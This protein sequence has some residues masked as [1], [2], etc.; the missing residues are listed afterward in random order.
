MNSNKSKASLILAM[1]I[2]GTIGVFR[3]YIPF[4]SGFIAFSRGLLGTSFLLLTAFIRGRRLSFQAIRNNIILLIVSG[5]LIG[6]NWILLFESYRYTTVAT[7]TLCYYMAPI[8][9][10]LASPLV[11]SEKLSARKI[12]CV[13]IALFG[14]VLVSGIFK[15]EF[16]GV[17]ELYG[18]FFGLGAAV[19]Y[20]SVIILNKKL[21]EIPANEKTIMQLLSAAIVVLP[22]TLFAENISEIIFTPFA[23]TLLLIVG[24]IHTGLSY[25][26]YFNSFK[27]LKAQTVALL[28]YIDPAVAILASALVL[29]EKIG[30]FEIFGAVLI[31][32]ST[33][34]S[35]LFDNKYL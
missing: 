4:P 11:L 15:T 3:N 19:L 35:E 21:V 33:L 2:F 30:V 9:V 12:L 16:N 32:G 1:S 14:M 22:Y 31:L 18:V 25:H 23:L 5:A 10:I 17:S 7:S 20:A 29:R 8:F 13:I 6:F 27:D 24:I 34:V 28:S 26:L